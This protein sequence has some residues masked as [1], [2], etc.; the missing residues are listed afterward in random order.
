[1]DTTAQK[2]LQTP[3]GAA[4]AAMAAVL[5][6]VVDAVVIG[7]G[8]AGLYMLYRLRKLGLSAR[9]FEAGTGVGG[10]WYWN[11]Y[12]GA[13]C[14][15]ESLQYSYSFDDPLQQEWTWTERYPK[16]DEILRYI[17]H[18]ADRFDLRRNIHFNTRVASAVYDEASRLWTVRTQQG[19]AVTARFVISAVGC[20]SAARVPQVS[21]LE[22]FKGRW[23][24]TGTW[25]QDEKV[26][27]TGQRV[28]VIGTG[29]SGIQTIP[30][31]ARQA[32]ELVVFQRTPN[33]SIPAWNGPLSADVQKDWKSR[34]PEYRERA[35]ETRSGI[36]Y[37]YGTR[38]A[39]SVSDEER[40]AEYERRW[41]RG[42]TNF[43]HAFN[44]LYTDQF[45]ND[46]AS[47]FV[48]G[49]IH[50]L[51]KDP[52][53]A[54]L[55]T[56]T[57]HAIGTKR[58]CVDSDYYATFNQPHVKLVSLKADPIRDIVPEGIR[59][60]STTHAVDA[61]VFA[62]GYDAVTG[63]LDLIDIRGIGGQ[64]LKAKWAQGPRT[65][66][67]LMSAGFP[68]LLTITGPSSPSVLTNV[69]MSIEQHVEWIAGC[70]AHMQAHAQRSVACTLQAEDDWMVHAHE[71]ASK[72][73]FANANS[74]YTGANIPGK[75][76]TF[77]PYIGGLGNY[78]V[79]CNDVVVAGYRGFTFS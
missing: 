11:C 43:T 2:P 38:P 42:G 71:V 64:S 62:T 60:E 18:V 47:A 21:G 49:K 19:D 24:H 58:I 65:Y 33:F 12:P 10:T 53:V 20:L 9:V 56:P 5:D 32:R 26:D 16:Q 67:G 8:F 75:P 74:W 14:D 41:T 22:S 40:Q 52:A 31:I 34:Y 50:G 30:V 27:F 28:A 78:T 55:L 6:A 35:R 72:T 69:I 45:A 63:S 66:L 7:A 17:N 25:P 23:F 61:I 48:R 51:V 70:L 3:S 79:I 37:D 73:L 57:D 4:P 54:A 29:S 59:T 44:D 1:M 15:V 76:R 39:A 77:L 13:R 46:T 68:N 36:L